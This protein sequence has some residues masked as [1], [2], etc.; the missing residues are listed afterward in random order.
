M[1]NIIY[2]SPIATQVTYNNLPEQYKSILSL[3]NIETILEMKF[4]S[5]D[6][7]IYQMVRMCEKMG[8]DV[9]KEIVQ[10]VIK[11]EEVYLKQI[12]VM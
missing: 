9:T 10:A 11:A 6:N 12:G 2:D 5:D 3:D 4:L 8:L 1:S 7:D